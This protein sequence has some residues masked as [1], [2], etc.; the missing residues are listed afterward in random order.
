MSFYSN[1]IIYYKSG[2]LVLPV[3]LIDQ[4]VSKCLSGISFV[5]AETAAKRS[6]V[7]HTEEQSEA[8]KYMRVR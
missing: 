7:I 6:V 8:C 1:F 2:F 4:S 5:S 3:L